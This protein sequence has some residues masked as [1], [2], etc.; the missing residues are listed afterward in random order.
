MAGT[1]GRAEIDSLTQVARFASVLTFTALASLA[2]LPAGAQ[3]FLGTTTFLEPTALSSAV[4]DNSLNST[5]IAGLT[6]ASAALLTD[7]PV[8]AM[9]ETI[10]PMPQAA[11]AKGADEEDFSDPGESPAHVRITPINGS[12]DE[13]GV[14]Y[15]IA[16]QEAQ[17]VLD[18][19]GSWFKTL[20]TH[21]MSWIGTPYRRGGESHHGVDCSGLTEAVFA[22][23]GIELPRTAAEQYAL[24]HPV[25]VADLKQGDLIFFRNTYKHGIS[26]VGIYLGDGMFIHAAGHRHGVIVSDFSRAYYQHRFA[27]ARRVAEPPTPAVAKISANLVPEPDAPGN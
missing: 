17:G 2:A 8:N 21:A 10:A 23:Q 9:G 7:A 26:H 5:P 20:V 3:S 12:R 25:E 24:G 4:T 11:P 14:E 16:R 13:Y 6:S 22:A 27:G 19:V 15:E 1:R 18:R